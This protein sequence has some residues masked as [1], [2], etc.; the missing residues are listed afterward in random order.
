MPFGNHC[1]LTLRKKQTW[2]VCVSFMS[3][4]VFLHDSP[5]TEVVR[6]R[7]GHKKHLDEVWL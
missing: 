4:T 5:S 6:I 2:D 1:D 3:W 7:L